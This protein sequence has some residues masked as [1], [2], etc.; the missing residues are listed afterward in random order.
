MSFINKLEGCRVNKILSVHDYYQLYF[1]N[2]AVL[3]IY[4]P[5]VI[6]QRA[7]SFTSINS[8][9]DS[10]VKSIEVIE[11]DCVT[12]TFDDDLQLSI[13]VDYES[14]TGPEALELNIPNEPIMVWD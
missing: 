10:I 2:D 6:S 9:N 3:T 7:S 4:N 5:F 12:F 8:L 14:F 13:K 1:D 11:H